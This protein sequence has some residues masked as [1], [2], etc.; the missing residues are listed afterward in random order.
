MVDRSFVL[1]CDLL[2]YMFRF[3]FV[4]LCFADSDI[5]RRATRG[6][7]RYGDLYLYFYPLLFYDGLRLGDQGVLLLTTL[8]SLRTRSLYASDLRFQRIITIRLRAFSTLII[9]PVDCRVDIGVRL[10]T[11]LTLTMTLILISYSLRRVSSRT[12]IGALHRFLR[13]IRNHN[14]LSSGRNFACQNY[15][16]LRLSPYLHFYILNSGYGSNFLNVALPVLIRQTAFIIGVIRLLYSLIIFLTTAFSHLR[17]CK[18]LYRYQ[19]G[20]ETTIV[21]LENTTPALKRRAAA[22]DTTS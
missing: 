21:K 16:Y 12:V 4:R 11:V 5:R 10:R 14:I 2:F 9:Y 13:I 22:G 8:T 18:Y 17:I 19:V 20:F 15:L 7:L 6:T 3:S 1:L